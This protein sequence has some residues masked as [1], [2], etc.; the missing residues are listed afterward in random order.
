VLLSLL[1]DA[2]LLS[3]PEPSRGAFLRF[4]F[5]HPLPPFAPRYRA[6]GKTLGWMEFAFLSYFSSD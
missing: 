4:M 2:L 3:Y 5:S 1:V 6:V